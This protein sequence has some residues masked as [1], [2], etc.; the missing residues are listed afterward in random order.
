MRVK[1]V[2]DVCQQKRQRIG[3]RYLRSLIIV[4]QKVRRCGTCHESNRFLIEDTASTEHA[5]GFTEIAILERTIPDALNEESSAALPPTDRG[6][7]LRFHHFDLPRQPRQVWARTNSRQPLVSYTFQLV[8]PYHAL[9]ESLSNSILHPYILAIPK[10]RGIYISKRGAGSV[11]FCGPEMEICF[12]YPACRL[13]RAVTKGGS[14]RSRFWSRFR[15]R[16]PIYLNR[17]QSPSNKTNNQSWSEDCLSPSFSVI[18]DPNSLISP[19]RDRQ[20]ARQLPPG[21]R[22]AGGL[23]IAPYTAIDSAQAKTPFVISCPQHFVL[24]SKN[25]T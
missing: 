6:E 3:Y 14:F 25:T 2:P 21:A 16:L 7:E 1:R 13:A 10:E 8:L 23:L 24:N 18:F 9:Q 4:I 20:A 11:A 22:V 5:V 15:S 12:S 17:S 19:L